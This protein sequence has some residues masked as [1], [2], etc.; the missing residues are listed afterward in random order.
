M[1]LLAISERHAKNAQL[2]LESLGVEVERYGRILSFNS[3]GLSDGRL[4]S[5]KIRAVGVFL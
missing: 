1:K 4:E 5:I 2:E 3:F